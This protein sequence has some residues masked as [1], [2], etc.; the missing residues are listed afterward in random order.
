MLG[1]VGYLDYMRSQGYETF[2]NWI[3][4]SYD[5]EQDIN[6]RISMIANVCEDFLKKDIRKFYEDTA[7]LRARNRE[8]FFNTQ[9]ISL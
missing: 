2:D 8:T 3:D 1:P 6:K 5:M 7:G 4:E 9:P